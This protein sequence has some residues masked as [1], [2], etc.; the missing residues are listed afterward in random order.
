MLHLSLAL[1]NH[2]SLKSFLL[3]NGSA[4]WPR[5]KGRTQVHRSLNYVAAPSLHLEYQPV[6]T[7]C[8]TR[9]ETRTKVLC[10]S[11]HC[12]LTYVLLLSSLPFFLYPNLV[13]G[14]S[15]PITSP[16]HPL[17]GRHGMDTTFSG[18]PWL[19]QCVIGHSNTHQGG[20]SSLWGWTFTA[21]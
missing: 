10:L 17:S 20:L 15:S 18:T 9:K 5:I 7:I 4:Y 11:F 19:S 21:G 13:L 1:Q 14:C 3:A 6:S 8:L 12:S 16:A 2:P